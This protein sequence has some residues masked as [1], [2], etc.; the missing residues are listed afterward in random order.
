MSESF[1]TNRR[2][3]TAKVKE[4]H[5]QSDFVLGYRNREDVTLL[6][7]KTLIAP[8]VNVLTNVS[9]RIGARK[10]YI[11][12]GPKSAVVA[13]IK[14]PYDW[15]T[16]TGFVRHLRPGFLTSAGNDGKLQFRYV[17]AN[18]VVSWIDLLSGLTSTDFNYCDYWDATQLQAYLLMVNNTPN[19]YEWSGG[20]TTFASATSTTLTTTGTKSWAELGF[21]NGGTRAITINGVSATYSGGEGTTTLTGVSVDFSAT[22]VHTVIFQTVRV[23]AN[24]AMTGLPTFNNGLI[25][26][27]KNQIYIGCFTNNSVYVSKVNNYK[28][29]SF[30]TP[31]LVGEGAILTLDG[32]PTALIPQEDQLY[33]SAGKSQWYLTSFTLSADLTAETLDINPLKTTALQASI[34]QKATTKI[35][36]NIVF[37]SN[38][39][40]VNSLGR[41]ANVVLT[42]QITDLSFPIVNDMNNYDFTD[43]STFYFKQFM[44]MA[45]PKMGLI[46]V[47]NMTNP[48]NDYWE[49]PLTIPVGGFSEID[50]ELYG[51]SY[52]TSES[53]KLFTGGADRATSATDGNPY[54]CNAVFAFQ[55]DGIRPK[56]KSFNR[57]FSEGYISTNTT[58]NVGNT[59]LVPA[60]GKNINQV[61]I[62]NGSGKYVLS[63]TNDNSLGKFAL[64][65]SP[66]GGNQ[67]F[68][69]QNAL[70]PYFAVY[71]TMPRI[72]Y[73]S[74]S[75]SFF[76][77]GT[78]QNWE[79]LAFGTNSSP[80]SE[81]ETDITDDGVQPELVTES[82]FP[83]WDVTKFPWLE[84]LPW[85]ST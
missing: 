81:N 2:I 34:S 19:I 63:A 12:D 70:P 33:I 54:F 39:P 16:H 10:G 40:I 72:P 60:T 45:I 7:A 36:N 25:A 22:A 51:H 21:Y 56:S 85:Q 29:Y 76:S 17:D 65:K 71:K 67:V 5:I 74:F 52:A 43:A 8:S 84:A 3:G 57:F 35:K 78:N 30:S 38:E 14:T 41:V 77:Y 75:P 80:T 59:F 53:Y 24:S 64:G 11:L 66:L 26:N 68:S 28:D 18:N 37:I 9:G 27:L 6:S 15:P 1:S 73:F 82:E 47:Y 83:L 32:T 50:G 69:P 13:P 55:N 4:I 23:T 20:I 31:R 62:I 49:A 48:K 46:R 58:L 44:Y 42:P 61:L 79:L